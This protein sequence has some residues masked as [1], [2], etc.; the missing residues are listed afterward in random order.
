MLIDIKYEQ[1]RVNITYSNINLSAN[2]I[3]LCKSRLYK[4]GKQVFISGGLVEKL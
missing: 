3:V 2:K 1:R 4:D